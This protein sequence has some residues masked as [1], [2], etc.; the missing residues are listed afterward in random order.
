MKNNKLPACCLA[1][2]SLARFLQSPDLTFCIGMK[3][4]HNN[5][6]PTTVRQRY[7]RKIAKCF[8]SI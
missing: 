8:T 2:V 4:S 3:L 5:N 7:L 1:F 6:K